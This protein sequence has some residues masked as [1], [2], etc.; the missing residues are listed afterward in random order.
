M[1]STPLKIA[2]AVWIA[3]ASLHRDHGDR[4][5][6][7]TKE[8]ARAARLLKPDVNPQTLSA[9]LSSHLV[10]NAKPN[11]GHYRMLMRLNDELRRLYRPGDRSHPERH[12]K[13]KP[14]REE[15]PTEYWG[16]LDWYEEKYCRRPTATPQ[17]DLAEQ[18]WGLGQEIWA[19]T[20]ADSY[21]ES[22]R[23]GW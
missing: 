12:G 17:P 9:H 15:I 1:T 10:A 14:K 11:G 6:F 19:D 2:D 18:M 13:T 21:V 22:L 5:S 20:D 4:E 16:L 7:T 23:A 8:I 3:L